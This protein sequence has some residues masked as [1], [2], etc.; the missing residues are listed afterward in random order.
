MAGEGDASL[1][2]QLL[3]GLVSDVDTANAV[4]NHTSS[5]IF[6]SISNSGIGS[7]IDS[8]LLCN[9]LNI[10]R[11]CLTVL[12]QK[13]DHQEHHFGLGNS[14]NSQGTSISDICTN[15]LNLLCHPMLDHVA[16]LGTCFDDSNRV[17]SNML[18]LLV[19]CFP[20]ASCEAQT[21]ISFVLINL[22]S[23]KKT[24][25]FCLPV[26]KALSQ[27]YNS[28]DDTAGTSFDQLAT[29]DLLTAVEEH[30][31]TADESFVGQVLV[32]LVPSILTHC[33]YR[34]VVIVRL[35]SIVERCYVTASDG[36][37]SR[38]CF[39]IC[40]LADALLTPGI[41]PILTSVKLLCSS[42]LW[43]CV[44]KGLQHSEALTRKRGIYLLRRAVD[45]A[46]MI[47]SNTESAGVE[48]SCDVLN[49][50]EHLCKL[51][52]FWHE[53]II[54]LETLEEKQ[55]N[56]LC[57]NAIFVELDIFS[58]Y[59]CFNLFCC[60][61]SHCDVYSKIRSSRLISVS[62]CICCGHIICN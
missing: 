21:K 49:S 29:D 9:Q 2:L 56:F 35:W 50:V 20:F 18:S 53:L 38:C 59:W 8:K 33:D 13:K 44:Q 16:A 31:L 24:A 14:I 58:V 55:V 60:I 4:L 10:L 45:F 36:Y 62:Q 22:L 43:T 48:D 42:V 51:P 5:N 30:C 23:H 57:K 34:E 6:Q 25:S 46:G 52:S 3:S 28:K 54:L 47:E 27:V 61:L 19:S 41:V 26:V 32:Q 37:I 39:L 12:S 7:L 11:T 40:G 1:V 15:V 17:L